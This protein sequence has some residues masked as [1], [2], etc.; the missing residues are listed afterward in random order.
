MRAPSASV[1]QLLGALGSP[2]VQQAL[3]SMM[4]GS[5]GSRSVSPP[6]GS[7]IPVAAITNLLATQAIIVLLAQVGHAAHV[8]VSRE[9]ISDCA[10][11]TQFVQQELMRRVI[12]VENRELSATAPPGI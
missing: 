1:S 6:G 2:A 7:P 9:S 10:T 8:G 3:S 5:A 4:L 11:F 12:D